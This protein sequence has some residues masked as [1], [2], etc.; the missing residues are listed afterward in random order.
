VSN[1]SLFD[2]ATSSYNELYQ[3]TDDPEFEAAGE[4]LKSIEDSKD[5]Q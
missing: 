1:I 5:D 4:L 2:Q 3:F